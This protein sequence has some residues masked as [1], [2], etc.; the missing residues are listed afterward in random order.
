MHVWI[1]IFIP[2]CICDDL[3]QINLTKR[4]QKPSRELQKLPYGPASGSKPDEASAPVAPSSFSPPV[5]ASSH[6]ASPAS[7]SNPSTSAEE[8]GAVSPSAATD[9]KEVAAKKGLAP[10][11]SSVV[12][13]P[14]KN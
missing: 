10:A 9:N 12:R 14:P 5:S 7:S 1:I 3:M 6:A 11:S 8:K 4:S 2:C 13:G